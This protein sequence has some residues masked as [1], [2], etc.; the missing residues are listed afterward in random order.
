RRFK[1]AGTVAL[2]KQAP[3]AQVVPVCIDE[4]WRL[5]ARGML[6]IPVGTTLKAWVG[7]PIPR[8][9]DE[10]L[11]AIVADCEAQIQP[12]IAR[13]RGTTVAGVLMP[14]EAPASNGA[15]TSHAAAHAV[16]AAPASP[17][18]AATIRSQAP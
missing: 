8:R 7:D 10:D 18:S 13:M 5:M 6:P 17:P 16:E 9:A 1:P 2:L 4:S 3:D 12:A 11:Y 15:D 14:D